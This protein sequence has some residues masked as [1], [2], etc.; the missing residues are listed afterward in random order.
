[1]VKAE[2]FKKGI[3]KEIIDEVLDKE[4]EDQL[5]VKFLEKKKALLKRMDVAEFKAKMAQVLV[6]RGFS[7]EIAKKA[8]DII[9][10]EGVK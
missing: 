10:A 4:T 2:L 1:M 3:S 5:A 8:V 6:R 7:W 9:L